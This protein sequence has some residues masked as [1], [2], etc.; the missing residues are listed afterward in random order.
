MLLFGSHGVIHPPWVRRSPGLAGSAKEQHALADPGSAVQALDGVGLDESTEHS[1]WEA[2]R[3]ASHR[4][5]ENDPDIP[6]S[7]LPESVHTQHLLVEYDMAFE[8]L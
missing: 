3:V 5:S 8:A 7:H 4:R 1:S 6:A 2:G